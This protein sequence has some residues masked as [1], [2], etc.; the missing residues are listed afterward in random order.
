MKWMNQRKLKAQDSPTVQM[1]GVFFRQH[2][3]PV[4]VPL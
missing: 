2:V 1:R 3:E 4:G